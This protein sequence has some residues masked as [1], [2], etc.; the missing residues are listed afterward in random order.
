VRPFIQT[1]FSEGGA[2]VSP[3]GR[4]VAYAVFASDQGAVYV[5]PFGDSERFQVSVEGGVSPCWSRDG[6]ALYFI[7]PLGN[8]V[9][10]VEVTTEPSFHAGNPVRILSGE[11][12]GGYIESYDVHPDGKRLAFVVNRDLRGQRVFHL[13]LNIDSELARLV[14]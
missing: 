2:D 3:D 14:K 13:I 4:W 5:S 7:E 1:A 6:K 11:Q 9:Y 8:D 10:R 12:L